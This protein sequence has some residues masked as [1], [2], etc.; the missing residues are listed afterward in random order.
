[1]CY[2]SAVDVQKLLNEVLALIKN[3]FRNSWMCKPGLK[4]EKREGLLHFSRPG[5]GAREGAGDSIFLFQNG[6]NVTVT[7][8]LSS[9]GNMGQGENDG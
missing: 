9:E 6:P 4:P 5:K 7:E 8:Q 3:S 1:M 2:R